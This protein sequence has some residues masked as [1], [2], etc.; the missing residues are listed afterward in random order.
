[1]FNFALTVFRMN[2]HRLTRLNTIPGIL[3]LGMLLSS[4]PVH[5]EPAEVNEARNLVNRL[6]TRLE[7]FQKHDLNADAGIT[8]LELNVQMEDNLPGAD[9][10]GALLQNFGAMDRNGDGRVDFKEFL[11]NDA[12]L[13]RMFQL[14]DRNANQAVSRDEL[15]TWL[16]HFPDAPSREDINTHFSFA[17][18]NRNG[19]ISY[20]EFESMLMAR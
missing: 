10:A 11:N 9:Q 3:V 7:Q 16:Q 4:L 5:A 15:Y 8:E 18:E 12:M 14:A 13:R 1:M 20:T 2:R 17:D 19:S 6:R